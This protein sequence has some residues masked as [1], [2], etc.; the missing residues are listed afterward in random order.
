M[1]STAASFKFNLTLTENDAHVVLFNTHLFFNARIKSFII[2][3][4]SKEYSS[5]QRPQ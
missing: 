4:L 3:I 2:L 5:F 1:P